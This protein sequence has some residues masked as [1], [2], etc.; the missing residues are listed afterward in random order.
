[1]QSSIRISGTKVRGLGLLFISLC[2]ARPTLAHDFWLQPDNFS[3]PPHASVGMS[4]QVGHGVARQGWKLDTSRVLLFRSTGPQGVQDIRDGLKPTSGLDVATLRFDNSG[5]YII[6]FQTSPALSNLPFIR[7]NDYAKVE[8]L[9]PALDYRTRTHTSDQPGR[10]SYSRRCKAMVQV[11]LPAANSPWVTRP[12]GLSLEIVPERNP[13]MLA[14][15][16]PLPVQVLYQGRPLQGALVK[17]TN[18]E[19]DGRPL[20]MHLSDK[21]GRA[22]FKVPHV[23]TWLVNVIWTQPIK[24]NPQADFETTFSS[25]TFAYPPRTYA[26]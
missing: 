22:A 13:Y 25:L 24:G 20:E 17:L 7:Y 5:T 16:E 15:D 26:H 6:S 12:I 14:S 11:G 1:M 3:L 18:L 8:G 2:W 4:I 9:T 21:D 10:E 23:G 19:F